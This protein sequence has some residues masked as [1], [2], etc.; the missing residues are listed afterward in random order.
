MDE[1]RTVP[2]D[3]QTL[4]G[5]I[6]SGFT[7]RTFLKIP[8]HT[9]CPGIPLPGVGA[10][11]SFDCPAVQR[12]MRV[13]NLVSEAS[14]IHAPI[15]TTYDQAVAAL[16]RA[17]HEELVQ[18]GVLPV[19]WQCNVCGSSVTF[20]SGT[21]DTPIIHGSDCWVGNALVVLDRMRFERPAREIAAF[22]HRYGGV[23]D[24]YGVVSES[25]VR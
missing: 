3:S 8:H 1:S 5:E 2:I 17:A 6:D 20:S 12:W 22:P 24:V 19:T 7:L 10:A 18:L 25:G 14:A 11:H 13:S 15:L 23:V 9:C 16:R 4:S 21:V